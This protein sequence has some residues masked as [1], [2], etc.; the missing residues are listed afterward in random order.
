MK[1]LNECSC[2]EENQLRQHH[3]VVCTTCNPNRIEQLFVPSSITAY[4]VWKYDH[5]NAFL[6]SSQ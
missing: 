1:N 4:R 2:I 5:Q 6:K 3:G